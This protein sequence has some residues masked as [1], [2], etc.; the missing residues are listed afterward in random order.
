MYE[1]NMPEGPTVGMALSCGKQLFRPRYCA[2][3]SERN[4]P[5]GVWQLLSI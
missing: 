1:V 2:D 5:F 3:Y 4:V